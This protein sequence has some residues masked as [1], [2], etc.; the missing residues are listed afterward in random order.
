MSRVGTRQDAVRR[1]APHQ[2]TD[3]GIR[4]W[5]AELPER[6]GL[7]VATFDTKV[8]MVRRLPGSAARKAASEVRRHRSGRVVDSETFYVEDMAGPLC[9]GELD[10]ARSWGAELA[11]VL[12][13]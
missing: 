6:E 5:L 7:A 13:G 8:Q 11:S 10:R 9:A 3:R 2:G 1:G 12:V 4:E